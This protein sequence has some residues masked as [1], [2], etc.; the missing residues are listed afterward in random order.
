M[1]LKISSWETYLDHQAPPSSHSL[2]P[3][4]PSHTVAV[5]S[6]PQQGNIN[7]AT[8][9]LQPQ[10]HISSHNPMTAASTAYAGYASTGHAGQPPNL[11]PLSTV[12]L[13]HQGIDGSRQQHNQTYN[14]YTNGQHHLTSVHV[15][16]ASAQGETVARAPA[17]EIN[18]VN[19]I[20]QHHEG[21]GVP[22]EVSLRKNF[23][24]SHQRSPSPGRFKRSVASF[25]RTKRS[26]TRKGGGSFRRGWKKGE[27]PGGEGSFKDDAAS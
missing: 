1:S 2:D 21:L 24:Q 23:S 3:P 9:P 12:G 7:Q 25:R 17:H 4:Q 16:T 8:L 15:P 10:Y 6:A 26:F 27:D 18:P 11:N 14:K 13:M 19:G 20:N 5:A 22:S